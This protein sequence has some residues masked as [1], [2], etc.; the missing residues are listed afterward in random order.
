MRI[1]IFIV[2]AVI[3]ISLVGLAYESIKAEPPMQNLTL[4]SFNTVNNLTGAAL[5]IE[6]ASI[7]KKRMTIKLSNETKDILTY[8]SFYAIEKYT[9]G[10]WYKIPYTSEN[11]SWTLEGRWLESNDSV[12][13]KTGWDWAYGKLNKGHYR[14]IKPVT[15]GP[16][17]K[18]SQDDNGHK[19]YYL[20]AEFEVK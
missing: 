18:Q 5:T 11:I 4:S 15:S 2:T 1:K 17:G 14:I 8:G 12:E 13:I 3:L 19:E 9:S 6:E 7:T 20:A 16:L 10:K